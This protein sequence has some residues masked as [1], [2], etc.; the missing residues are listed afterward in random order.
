MVM[1][2]SSKQ[3]PIGRSQ[4]WNV[5][6]GN[7][8]QWERSGNM[9]EQ[10]NRTTDRRNSFGGDAGGWYEPPTGVC[11]SDMN[12]KREPYQVSLYNQSVNRQ[13]PCSMRK[14]SVPELNSHYDRPPMAHRGSLT[15]LDPYQQD[16]AVFSR[17]P[18]GF[19][20]GEQMPLN[21]AASDYAAIGVTRPLW[22]QNQSGRS[23]P[24]PAPPPPP[25][26]RIY[27]E[28]NPPGPLPASPLGKIMPEGQHISSQAPSPALY[29]IE[30]ATHRYGAEAPSSLPGFSMYSDLNGRLGDPSQSTATCLVIDPSSQGMVMRQESP[31]PYVIGQQQQAQ[32]HKQDPAQRMLRQQRLQFHSFHQSQ[33]FQPIQQEHPVQQPQQIQPVQQPQ[34]MQPIQQVQQMPLMQ[35]TQ[36]AQSAQQGQP[37]APP[38]PVYDPNPPLPAPA[39][40]S[41]TTAIPTQ[42]LPQLPT[43]PAPPP[44]VPQNSLAPVDPKQA[45][46]PE[47]L[48]ILRNEG[49]SESTITSLLQQGFDSTAMLAVMEQNDIHSV[50]PN[51]GQARVLSRV[52]VSCRRPL[53]I[54]QHQSPLVRG[55]S[56]SFSHR[57]DIY[58]H[59][60]PPMTPSMDSQSIQPPLT[61]AQTTFPRIAEVMGQRPSSAPSQQLLEASGYPIT[62]SPGP[63]SSSL[64]PVQSRSLSAYTP[65]VD[66]PM[67]SLTTVPQQVPLP[68][69]TTGVQPQILGL[70]QQLQAPINVM[71]QQTPALA[72]LSQSTTMPTL[73]AHQAPKAYSTNYTV[74]MELMKRDRSLATMSN[75][76]PSPHTVRKIGATPH[77]S[78]LVPVGAAIQTSCLA[79]Q[80]LSRRTGPPVIVSTMAS[81]DT[82]KSKSLPQ[83]PFILHINLF[84]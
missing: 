14:S 22:N 8:S 2:V 7:E 80:K 35:Q 79:N 46:D 73:P 47:F 32:Q 34:Q 63:F 53:D 18:D 69:H 21:R 83:F 75:L 23:A 55:R 50:A 20:H 67:P 57:S 60:Q 78:A 65:Q 42:G 76:Q 31:S 62:R 54:L 13:D 33:S 45:A 56:N 71:P 43:Q 39:P 29:T 11:P 12:M 40:V 84:S 72:V 16:P 51:L 28:P 10:Q 5:L 15:P 70:Q 77:E 24:T 82:S 74:P 25:P 66:L 37:V 1:L 68:S 49:L 59:Q 6:G 17:P 52:A 58:V 44:T 81:P 41:V 3:L 38:N 19:Y 27:R 36:P 26:T 30:A 61:P 4:S 9:Y 64:L 48:A